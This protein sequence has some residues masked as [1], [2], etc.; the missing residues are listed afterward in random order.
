MKEAEEMISKKRNNDDFDF[1]S[2]ITEYREE[3]S[4]S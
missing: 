2:S 4:V 3:S 1:N